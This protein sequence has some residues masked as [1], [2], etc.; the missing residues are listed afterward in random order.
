MT[1]RLPAGRRFA[2]ILFLLLVGLAGAP[3]LSAAEVRPASVPRE[4]FDPWPGPASAFNEGD[5][6]ELVRVLVAREEPALSPLIAAGSH[7]LA[8][9]HRRAGDLPAARRELADAVEWNPLLLHAL[10][11]TD[12]ALGGNLP[13]TVTVLDALI[14]EL[15]TGR[16]DLNAV[17][18]AGFLRQ[19]LLTTVG[20]LDRQ[21]AYYTPFQDGPGWPAGVSAQ[22]LFHGDPSLED[23]ASQY[24]WTTAFQTAQAQ[25]A[26]AL[27]EEGTPLPAETQ[28][29]AERLAAATRLQER[30]AEIFAQSPSLAGLRWD[31]TEVYPASESHLVAWIRARVVCRKL[32]ELRREMADQ[33]E[34]GSPAETAS[35]EL[36][37]DFAA[38]AARIAALLDWIRAQ[39]LDLEGVVTWSPSFAALEERMGREVLGPGAVDPQY[40]RDLADQLARAYAQPGDPT[41]EAA[42]RQAAWRE[43]VRAFTEEEVVLTET[44]E[45]VVTPQGYFRLLQTLDRLVAFLD[46]CQDSTLALLGRGEW[47]AAQAR[48][49][50]VREQAATAREIGKPLAQFASLFPDGRRLAIS[51][52]PPLAELPVTFN[53][54]FLR[55]LARLKLGANIRAVEDFRLA[56]VFNGVLEAWIRGDRVQTPLAGPPPPIPL[57][58]VVTDA[59]IQHN[60]DLALAPAP[61]AGP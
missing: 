6:L 4:L 30:T 9:W 61:A 10:L 46:R 49:E 19:W 14:Q 40:V 53:P 39:A 55:G 20:G 47:E 60:L 27:Q 1:M 18:G 29:E 17:I 44:E 56:R 48:Q 31:L 7:A 52:Q 41:I 50:F 13:Q 26:A 33:A 8:E 23:L 2:L 22:T 35:R 12:I 5:Y 38:G 45:E 32:T 42:R 3:G 54:Y 37:E 57:R 25:A 59:K 21:L 36:A 58:L 15:E 34:P 16:L 28:G 51:G 43:A 24:V 11:A